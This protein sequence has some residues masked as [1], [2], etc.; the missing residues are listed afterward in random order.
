MEGIFLMIDADLTRQWHIGIDLGGTKIEGIVLDGGYRECMRLKLETRASEGYGR[1]LERI[2]HIYHTLSSALDNGAHTLGVCTPGSISVKTGLLKNC[3]ATQL[4]G[5]PLQADLRERL[6]RPF[7]LEN[8]ANCFAIAE[9]RNGAGVGFGTVLGLVLGTGV[10]AG[11]V[12]D[13]RLL[14][15]RHGI[16]GEWGHMAINPDGP[17]CYCGRKGCVERYLSGSALEASYLEL[18]GQMIELSDIVGQARAGEKHSSVLLDK[19]LSDFASAV[20]NVVAVLDPGVIVIGGGLASI[21]ELYTVGVERLSRTVFN[22]SFETPVR[23]N[24]LGN[25]AGV[26]GAAMIGI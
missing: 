22:D 2:V 7:A 12:F 19:F 14:A 25:S 1:V 17:S 9:A 13:G 16:A 10:G 5:H 23:R 6:G 20:A 24:A 8:D 4:N 26:I 11:V 18:S 21:D 3:N 15:G